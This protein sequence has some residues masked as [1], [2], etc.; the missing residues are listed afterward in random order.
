M[1]ELLSVTNPELRDEWHPSRNII[2]FEKVRSSS[3]K[4]AWWRCSKN[5]QHEWEARIYHR[6]VQGIGCPFCSG[7]YISFERSLAALFPDIAAEWHPTKNE[8]LKPDQ[9]GPVSSKKI[10]WICGNGHEWNAQ[11]RNRTAYGTKCKKCF[12][13]THSLLVTHPDIASQ[14]DHSKNGQLS[15]SDVTYGSDR[16]VW[17]TCSQGHEW[18]SRVHDRVRGKGCPHC[19]KPKG[20]FSQK[21]E[22]LEA[23]FPELAKEWH[24]SLNA[25]LTPYQVKPGSNIKVWWQCTKNHSHAWHSSLNT[26][27]KG[28]GCP[29]CLRS[30]SLAD[31]F[32]EIAK[33]WHPIKNGGLKPS[34]LS[35]GSAKRVWW[36]CIENPLHEWESSVTNRTALG[37]IKKCPLCVGVGQAKIAE[38][39]S[40][41]Q[42]HPEI[43]KEWHPTKNGNL[44]PSLV[45][46]AS[47]RKVWWKCAINGDHEWESTV[48][49]RTILRSGCP[50]CEV[51]SHYTRFYDELYES[52]QANADFFVTFS[53]SLE[54][55]QQLSQQKL[56]H[57]LYL[58]QPYY[59]MVYGSIIT[60][61]ETY[62]C[63]AF[64]HKVTNDETL[65]E[66]LLT[67][68]PEFRE[69]KY[70]IADIIEW[71]KHT[72][73]K[74][75][76]YLLDIVWHNLPK[77]ELLYKNVLNVAFPKDIEALHR[78][79]SIRHDLVHRNGRSKTGAFH[80]IRPKEIDILLQRVTSFVTVIDDQLKESSGIV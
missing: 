80:V 72:K 1:R 4:K 71:K 54:F 58:Q 10:W 12:T 74:V 59:R 18:K 22:S 25:P 52:A 65:I 2:D 61:M 57:R 8:A 17:W 49:N 38:E 46:R 62:L 73:K 68:T 64:F 29:H 13:D 67:S 50:H 60:A 14:W 40:L 79:I 30:P 31:K 21:Y 66:K 35:Y 26:R 56:P 76:D 27:L 5:P 48:K 53:K 78:S 43:A 70:A 37:G 36:Q 47:G 33:E 55:L 15:P 28:R 39:K 69:R 11:V 7:R 45:A 20:L 34:D 42:R 6:A 51:D 63:D 32:P 23:S 77:I 24:P 19:P 44:L 16:V 41:Q 75:S 3:G 9:V